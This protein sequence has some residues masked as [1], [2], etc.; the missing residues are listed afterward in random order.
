MRTVFGRT[1]NGFST[2]ASPRA[3]M[4]SPLRQPPNGS[5]SSPL[6]AAHI[7]VVASA[8]TL[9]LGDW[10]FVERL[11]IAASA[12]IEAESS[13]GFGLSSFAALRAGPAIAAGHLGDREQR[14]PGLAG[15]VVQRKQTVRAGDPKIL[16]R[17][18]GPFR[19]MG[20]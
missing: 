11:W 4:P 20:A 14:F 10:G 9:R 12:T 3:S 17:I 2:R 5:S 13:S 18:T 16:D 7:V 1:P 19:Q 15:A 6:R 8:S